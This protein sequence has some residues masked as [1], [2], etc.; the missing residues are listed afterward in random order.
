M[1][2]LGVDIAQETFDVTLIDEVG[3]KHQAQFSNTPKGFRTLQSWLGKREVVELHACLEATN[4]YWEELAEFLYGQGYQVS[5]VNP[6]RTRGFA[7]SQMR[8]NKTDKEDSDVVADF[9]AAS[10]PRLWSPP[11]PPQRKLRAL[12]RHRE[13][14][15]KTLTQQTNRLSTRKDPDVRA[16]LQMIIET[17]RTEIAR[18]DDQIQTFIDHQPDFK[19]Q[20][21]LLQSITGIGAK[22]AIKLMAEIYDL[23]EYENA[24]AAA[25]DAGLTPRHYESGTSVRRKAKLSKQ[26]K[27]SV[28]GALYWPAI[29]AI[30]H[31]PIVRDLAE[32]LRARGKPKKVIIGAAMRKLLH[33]AYGV[34]SNK[35][36]FDPAYGR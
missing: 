21:A 7:Q 22:T 17:L 18:L 25:A 24:R 23:A 30:Q 15:G 1:A 27:G 10:K 34:L 33:L 29:T 3:Q 16:S 9:C 13:A 19:E 32:R 5:V 4:V 36:P 2:I 14:L 31:N 6:A 20:Q 35:T 12:S 11:S 26:G 8:R 28:R